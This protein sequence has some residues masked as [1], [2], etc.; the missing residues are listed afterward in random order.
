MLATTILTLN[1]ISITA[2]G[3]KTPE[4]A[5]RTE[6]ISLCKQS[7]NLPT[8]VPDWQWT[9]TY[10]ISSSDR[11]AHS[12]SYR[13]QMKRGPS[14]NNLLRRMN[15]VS[16]EFDWVR[17]LL[18]AQ[19]V[20]QDIAS[21]RMLML[22]LKLSVWINEMWIKPR[23]ALLRIWFIWHIYKWVKSKNIW[24]SKLGLTTTRT[25][26]KQDSMEQEHLKESQHQWVYTTLWKQ[27][28]ICDHLQIRT[29]CRT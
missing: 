4:Q 17:L 6:I 18:L 26:C 11:H 20:F 1:I 5:K 14:A 16:H 25:L 27:V 10:H 15:N 3:L 13:Q 12:I 28:L 23:K 22:S 24:Q 21:S 19:T 7:G 9:R 2:S 8:H 29:R